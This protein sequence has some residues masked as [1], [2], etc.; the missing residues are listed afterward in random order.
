MPN[1]PPYYNE[2]FDPWDLDDEQ[3][4][5]NKEFTTKLKGQFTPAKELVNQFML[6]VP[7]EIG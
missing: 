5:M 1:A 6:P 2:N 4:A 3:I 7:Q